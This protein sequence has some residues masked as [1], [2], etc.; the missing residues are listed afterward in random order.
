MLEMLRGPDDPAK[1]ESRAHTAAHRRHTP[2]TSHLFVPGYP[3]ALHTPK[4][5]ASCL[6]RF[7]CLKHSYHC[8][9]CL[10]L[11]SR[12]SCQSSVSSSRA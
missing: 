4:A 5:A 10:L 6:R 9:R 3:L 11:S 7:P 2:E 1:S 8:L 12:S